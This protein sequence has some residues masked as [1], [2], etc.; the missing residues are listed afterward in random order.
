M[1][2]KQD[3]HKTYLEAIQEFCYRYVS[4]VTENRI[5]LEFVVGP[6]LE[7]DAEEFTKFRWRSTKNL[8]GK[9]RCMVRCSDANIESL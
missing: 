5:S 3:V 1:R 6:V 4:L 9:G 2:A 7:L 8:K